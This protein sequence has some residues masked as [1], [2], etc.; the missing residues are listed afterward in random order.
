MIS[1]K[2]PV[3][4]YKCEICGKNIMKIRPDTEAKNLIVYCKC[5]KQEQLINIR[6]SAL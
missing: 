2:T 1:E 5:C 6:A 4:W 3:H